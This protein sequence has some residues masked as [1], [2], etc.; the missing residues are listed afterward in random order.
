VV[1]FK[2]LLRQPVATT[3]ERPVRIRGHIL[4]IRGSGYWPMNSYVQ[5][6]YEYHS[7]IVM[8]FLLY[9]IDAQQFCITTK[10]E[11]PKCIFTSYYMEQSPSEA[12][13][14]SVSQEIHRIV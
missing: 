2:A 12:N 7:V 14:F 13:S 1:T 11:F 10:Y 9:I 4:N 6:S 8:V 3:A 5:Y